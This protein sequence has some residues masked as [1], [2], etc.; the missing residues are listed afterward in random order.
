MYS[1]GEEKCYCHAFSKIFTE[2]I[3]N[4]KKMRNISEDNMN[5]MILTQ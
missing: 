5:L 3:Y 4:N 1:R 2:E